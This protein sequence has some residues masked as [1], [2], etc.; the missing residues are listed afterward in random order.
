MLFSNFYFKTEVYFK[1]YNSI[2]CLILSD[3]LHNIEYLKV[4]LL[5]LDLAFLCKYPAILNALSEAN[6][7]FCNANTFD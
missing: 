6:A 4:L 3:S 2:I 1:L 5:K 7:N